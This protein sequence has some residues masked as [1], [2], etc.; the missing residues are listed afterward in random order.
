[1]PDIAIKVP[2]QHETRGWVIN[3]T[4]E[5]ESPR[6]G[7]GGVVRVVE[8]RGARRFVRDEFGRPLRRLLPAHVTARGEARQ[9]NAQKGHR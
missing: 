6:D 7:P 1:M 4:T 9:A 3:P 2:A 5:G 8:P